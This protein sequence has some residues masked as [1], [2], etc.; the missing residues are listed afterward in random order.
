[1][2]N[3]AAHALLSIG[4]Y[5]PYWRI[6]PYRRRLT[7][8]CAYNPDSMVMSMAVEVMFRLCSPTLGAHSISQASKEGRRVLNHAIPKR[9]FTE[10]C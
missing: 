2:P 6:D 7:G 8:P 1:M 10:C 3:S 5:L 9:F 4:V